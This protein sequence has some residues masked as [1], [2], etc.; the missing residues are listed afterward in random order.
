MTATYL[1]SISE[2]TEVTRRD[3]ILS[4]TSTIKYRDAHNN[5]DKK[6]ME[7]TGEW[8]VRHPKYLHWRSSNQATV[9]W[10]HGLMGS[11]KSCL[12]HKVIEDLKL[13]TSTSAVMRFAY[14]Y[15]DGSSEQGRKDIESADKILRCLLQQLSRVGNDGKLMNSIIKVYTDI[16]LE[17]HLSENQCSDL[18]QDLINQSETTTIVID[19]LDECSLEVQNSFMCSI[20]EILEGCT[21]PLHI[22]LSSRHNLNIVDLLQDLPV[23]EIS[24]GHN[25]AE[26]IE[27]FIKRTAQQ[28]ASRPGDRR[29]YVKSGQSQELAVVYRLLEKASGMFRWVVLAF[30]FLHASVD[31]DAMSSRLNELSQLGQL[32]DLHDKIYD[33]ITRQVHAADEA[34]IRTRLTFMLHGQRCYHTADSSWP[35]ESIAAILE[36][37]EF[38][39]APSLENMPM[40]VERVR[41][42]CPGLVVV[43]FEKQFRFA[44]EEQYALT[45]PHLSVR[46][47]LLASSKYSGIFARH[48]GNV[49]LSQL[50]MKVISAS[51]TQHMACIEKGRNQSRS[52]RTARGN[53]LVDYSSKNLLNHLSILVPQQNFSHPIGK[54]WSDDNLLRRMLEDFLFNLYKR[55]SE[56]PD[57][58]ATGFQIWH[59]L[60]EHLRGDVFGWYEP[61]RSGDPYLPPARNLG[62]SHYLRSFGISL[63]P[64]KI[65]KSCIEHC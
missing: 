52:D 41:A 10:L 38:S 61:G 15:C 6:A 5:R 65:P 43:K 39:V 31:Y 56:L 48:P 11:G 51:G 53:A 23:T 22:F 33:D 9:L 60:L 29:K 49:Y 32:F 8:L 1:E 2:W 46:E 25:N 40:S 20:A 58:L 18:L 7:G 47:W 13:L 50:C 3:A 42:L 27:I 64:L 17:G 24:V 12:A 28:A 19:G 59:K 36:A 21:S 45:F 54:I 44:F 35:S 57:T 30:R 63:R 16:H 55:D 4:W 14:F 62:A 26:D 37:C 34:R